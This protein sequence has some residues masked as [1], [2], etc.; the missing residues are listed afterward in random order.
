MMGEVVK[1]IDAG[2]GAA[3]SF[4]GFKY[5][6]FCA[7]K[8]ETF[9]KKM[10]GVWCTVLP[11]QH[12]EDSTRKRLGLL[13]R[14]SDKGARVH[15]EIVNGFVPAACINQQNGSDRRPESVQK[16]MVGSSL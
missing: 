2:K 15:Q 4:Y 12:K 14:E 3:T 11:G 7:N 9:V 1:K 16:W 13:A 6:S 8:L 10:Y 5:W